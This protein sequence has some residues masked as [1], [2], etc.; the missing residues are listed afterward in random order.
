[1]L[2]PARERPTMAA[3]LR[4]E[5]GALKLGALSRRAGAAGVDAD[6]LHSLMPRLWD[7]AEGVV[8]PTM[9]TECWTTGSHIFRAEFAIV[10]LRELCSSELH[11][12]AL[13]FEI[14]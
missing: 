13:A 8:P 12:S 6:A 1:M 7:D 5:L 4:A 2:L 10:L 3:A 9:A 11:K 14:S